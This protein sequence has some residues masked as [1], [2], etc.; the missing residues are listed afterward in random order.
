MKILICLLAVTMSLPAGAQVKENIR[1]KVVISKDNPTIQGAQ[2]PAQETV[3]GQ[4]KR[5][6]PGH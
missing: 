3:K 1:Q 4:K 2:A 6:P 5:L